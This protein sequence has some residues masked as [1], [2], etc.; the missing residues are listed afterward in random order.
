MTRIVPDTAC[1]ESIDPLSIRYFRMR[2]DLVIEARRAA[3][4]S[5]PDSVLSQGA[6]GCGWSQNGKHGR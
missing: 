3:T 1:F 6:N 4:I 2:V 5:Y